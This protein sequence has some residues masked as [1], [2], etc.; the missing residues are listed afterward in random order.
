MVIE[1]A[2]ID[3]QLVPI[4]EKLSDPEIPVLSILAMGVVRYASV[5]GDMVQVKITPTYSGC[6]AMDVIGDDI[7]NALEEAGYKANVE[8]ILA[9]AW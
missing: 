4:F 3:E 2:H 5:E 8:L 7:I 6:P 9:P 1:K